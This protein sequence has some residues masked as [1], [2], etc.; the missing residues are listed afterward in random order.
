MLFRL[1]FDRPDATGDAVLLTLTCEDG[2]M[3]AGPELDYINSLY[4][5]A[6]NHLLEIDKIIAGHSRGFAFD[7]I[8]KTDLTALRMGIAEIKYTDTNAVVAVDAAVEIS[9]KYGTGKSGAFVNG[10]LAKVMA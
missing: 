10:I 3:P 9:K 5:A 4:T 2:E 6:V 8:F 7:R 1:C